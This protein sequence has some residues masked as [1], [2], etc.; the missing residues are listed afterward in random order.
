M[1]KPIDS[2]VWLIYEC[3]SCGLK[4]EARRAETVFPGGYL[5]GCGKQNKFAPIKSMNLGFTY[6]EEKAKPKTRI[7]AILAERETGV[8]HSVINML[9]HQGFS[10]QEASNML[11]E[12]KTKTSSR[13]LKELLRWALIS[14]QPA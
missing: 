9:K 3:P 6:A 10:V 5:C 2:D 1:I 14:G 11:R 7:E 4:Y 12:A 13:E 8:D